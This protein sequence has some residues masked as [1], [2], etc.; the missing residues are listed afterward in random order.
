MSFKKTIIVSVFF[1][2]FFFT[3]A[4]LLSANHLGGSSRTHNERVFFVKLTEDASKSDNEQSVNP[5]ITPP[6]RVVPAVV[7][8]KIVK[9]EKS[10][11]VKTEYKPVRDTRKKVVSVEVNPKS[12]NN[13]NINTH[14]LNAKEQTADNVLLA[15]YE[16][17]EDGVVNAAYDSFSSGDGMAP[18]GKGKGIPPQGIIEIIRNSIERAKTYP[19]LA[20]KR[21]IEGTVYI[22]FRINPQGKARDIKILKSS[23]YRI[24][25]RTTLDIVKKA[26]PFPYVNGP[27]EVPVVFRLKN[28]SKR[29]LL[30]KYE[31]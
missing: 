29:M 22:S 27:V 6:R 17:G 28:Y 4:L 8:T 20:R 12:E 19:V 13:H 14:E 5:G 11:Q 10:P 21:G 26:A 9:P 1:H 2:F 31:K 15:S 16:S 3:A 25:D 23:G 18:G 30:Q 24:L 7:K